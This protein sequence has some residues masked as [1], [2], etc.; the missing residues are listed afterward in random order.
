M[1]LIFNSKDMKV[2]ITGANGQLGRSLIKTKPE[3]IRVITTKKQNFNL[4]SKE[5]IHKYIEKEKPDW[6]INC[7]AY[8]NVDKAEEEKKLAYEINANGP[9]EI[10]R[11]L[12]NIGGNL[13]HISTDFV[14]DGKNN[15]PY[16]TYNIKNPINFYGYSKSIGEDNVL[17]ILKDSSQAVVI[18]TSW[19]MG[20]EGNNF[21]S[22]MIKLHLDKYEINVV[23]DQ[24][25]SPTISGSLAKACWQAIRESDSSNFNNKDNPILH[26]TNNGIASWYDVAFSVGEI[27]KRIGVLDKT[28]VINPIKS[29]DYPTKAKRPHYSVLDTAATKLSL[30]LSSNHWLFDLEKDLQKIKNENN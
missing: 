8:T 14:F 13:L 29:I 17:D 16:K 2:I 1:K 27:C 19:L 18:R 11:V 5:S 22:K 24:I 10:S 4:L 6:I 3:Y 12:K 7:G 21:A 15:E 30:N 28:A 26:W 25:G 9:K 20:P 23:S